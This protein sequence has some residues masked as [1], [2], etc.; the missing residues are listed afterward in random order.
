MLATP[1][2]LLTGLPGEFENPSDGASNP[3]IRDI[4]S[5]DRRAA[6]AADQLRLS[7]PAIERLPFDLSALEDG[8][9]LIN[10]DTRNFGLLDRRLD[11]QAVGIALPR[12]TELA[13]RPPRC[14]LVPDRYRLPLLRPAAQA[15]SALHAHSYRFQ[16]VETVLENPSYRWLPWRAWP[17]FERAFGQ[18]QSRLN[19]ALD[20]YESDYS[21]IYETVVGTFRQLATESARRLDATGH[22]VS[23]GFVDLVVRGM[24]SAVPTPEILR[25]RLSLRFRVG[26]LQLGSELWAEQRRAAEQRKLIEQIDADRR[27]E[28][29]QQVARERLVQDQL[30]TDQQRLRRQLETEEQDRR[31]EGEVKEQLR[32][33]KL[34]AARE[35]LQEVLSPLEEGAQ[36]LRA[37]VY[38]AAIALRTSLQKHQALRGSSA[39]RVRNLRKWF[40]L[41]N[42]VTNNSSA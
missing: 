29:R 28:Q 11:W 16:L 25:E 27:I 4:S 40:A 7:T 12:G 17:E 34:S 42:W 20:V 18:A 35:R 37:A 6:R 32:Q 30:W 31:R 8:G 14:G 24:L 23:V 10:V 19:A 33:L 26:V 2:Q 13:F 41:M 3:E 38:E 15:H 36:Q 1:N 21:T 39:R 9:I 5:V 22:P